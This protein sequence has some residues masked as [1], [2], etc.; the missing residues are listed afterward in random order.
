[1]FCFLGIHTIEMYNVCIYSNLCYKQ[2]VTSSSIFKWSNVDLNSEFSFSKNK[3]PSLPYYF[4]IA[5]GRRDC[6]KGIHKS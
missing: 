6:F 1:M 4:S 2:D 5:W 3:E